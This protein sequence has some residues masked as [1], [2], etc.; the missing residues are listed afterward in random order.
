MK[1]Q[2]FKGVRHGLPIALGYF[3]VSFGFGI[4]A[5]KAGLPVFA[6]VAISM[7]NL[8][9]AGQAAGV[10][11]I[12]ECGTLIEMALTQ[13]VINIRYALMA[14]SLSQKTDMSFTTGKR[15]VAAFGITDEIFAVASSQPGFITPE[16]MYGLTLVSFVGWTTG[17]LAGAAAGQ[18]LP[19]SVM[20]AMGIVLYGMFLA[21]IVP[22]SKK[23][24][25]ILFVVALAAVLSV[26]FKYLASGVSS[27]FAIIISA[28]AASAAGALL[29]P[30]TQA[31]EGETQ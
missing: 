16:Y 22:A 26:A 20:D 10:V 11:I 9:S 1:E 24:R 2:F 15:F 4:M 27:G 13:F 31:E 28:V 14:I 23:S 6:T 19:Q 21:I 30:R 3:S 29:F 18:L 25:A 8:T 7:T 5:V 12:A 17:T